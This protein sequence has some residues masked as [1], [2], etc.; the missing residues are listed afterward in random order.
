[1]KT[2]EEVYAEAISGLSTS[3]QV[4]IVGLIFGHLSLA[5]PQVRYVL[6]VV[7]RNQTFAEPEATEADYSGEWTEED[8]EAFRAQSFLLADEREDFNYGED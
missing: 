4:K 1:M 8:L 5:D 2:A 7:L 3:E 6:S